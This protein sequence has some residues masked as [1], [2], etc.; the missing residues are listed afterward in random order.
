[1]LQ[2]F[3]MSLLWTLT[4]LLLAIT[5]TLVPRAGL[6]QAV[7]ETQAELERID[8]EEHLGEKIPPNL[9]F[10]NDNGEKVPL[11]DYLGKGK[12]LLLTLGYYECPMLCNLVFNGLS[13]GVRQLDWK[14]GEEFQMITIGI[15]PTE[16]AELAHA[17]K[18]NYLNDFDTLTGES[19]WVF[20]VGAQGQI[21]ELADAVG[22]KYFYDEDRDEYA[23]PAVAFVIAE[24]GT[25]SRYLYGIEFRQQDLKLSLLEASEGKIGSSLDRLILY[26]FHYDPDAGGYVVMA[27]NVMRLGGATVL[28]ALTVLIALLRLGERRRSRRKAAAVGS[29]S[30]NGVRN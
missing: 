26:C 5:V 22:F 16:T 8:I 18:T 2:S 14:P 11:S 27:G 13:D 29:L 30:T 24:D 6:A 21:E 23:H 25:I 10:T 12:P 9:V 17:K 7:L 28:V 4:I 3:K 19:G 1:M 20:H 15:D